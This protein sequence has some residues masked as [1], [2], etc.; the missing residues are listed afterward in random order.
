MPIAEQRSFP[1]LITRLSCLLMI[2][3]SAGCSSSKLNAARENFYLR[4]YDRAISNLAE[5]PDTDKNRALFLMER[6]MIRA[7]RGE[8]KEATDDWVEAWLLAKEL[9]Y[10]S[11]SEGAASFAINERV[12]S[13]QGM[14]YERMLLHAFAAKS[15][16]AMGL[17]DDAAVESR[18]M[19]DR[20]EGL[21]KFPDDPYSR[22]IAGFGMEMIDDGDAASRQYLAANRLLP[23]LQIN[24]IGEISP[25]GKKAR[26]GPKKTHELVCFIAIG[27]APTEYGYSMRNVRWGKTPHAELYSNGV[28]LGRSYNFAN[29]SSLLSET[30]KRIAALRAL[31]DVSRIV[32]KEVVAD[33]V[34]EENELLGE[35]TRLLLY[36][37]EATGERRWETLPL[38]LHVARVPCDPNLKDYEVVFKGLNGRIIGRQTISTPLSRK[39]RTFVSFCRMN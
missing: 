12:K 21:D 33:S 3:F 5:V 11:I 9:D 2:L 4:K 36:S 7:T 6:G 39:D 10:Y 29:T 23:N 27:R 26:T 30:Q 22:Y 15:Y 20:F 24:N 38:W 31:K 37:F 16:C 14:P 19:L 1:R 34:S 18:N 28:R 32:L 8:H 35:I 25:K 13:F 17:W